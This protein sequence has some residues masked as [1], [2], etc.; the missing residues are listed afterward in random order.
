MPNSAVGHLDPP[1]GLT[2]IST[3][4]KTLPQQRHNDNIL[5]FR[6]VARVRRLGRPN[7]TGGAIVSG[8]NTSLTIAITGSAT[9][10]RVGGKTVLPEFFFWFVPP[11][12]IFWE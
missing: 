3:Q 1:D 11:L 4:G 12:L 9:V 5:Q 10:L 8:N 7:F 6:H 2:K